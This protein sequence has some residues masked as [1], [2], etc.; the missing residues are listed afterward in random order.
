M[1]LRVQSVWGKNSDFVGLVYRK[2]LV[3]LVPPSFVSET[4]T[5]AASAPTFVTGPI[6]GALADKFGAEWIIAPSLIMTLPWLPLLIL[7][8]SLP[9]FVVFFAMSREYHVVRSGETEADASRD[10]HELCIRACWVGSGHG[11]EINCESLV[12]VGGSR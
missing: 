5:V 9:G 10:L 1:T 3:P 6:V 8:K 2:L 4:I 12:Q 7:K 11:C